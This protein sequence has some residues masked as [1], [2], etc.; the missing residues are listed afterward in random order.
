[1]VPV[2]ILAG[3]LGDGIQAEREFVGVRRRVAGRMLRSQVPETEATA[4]YTARWRGQ[5][6]AQPTT[7]NC[8]R[9]FAIPTISSAATSTPIEPALITTS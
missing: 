5:R 8:W 4:G 7:G 3:R 6:V 1:M 2:E 9:L